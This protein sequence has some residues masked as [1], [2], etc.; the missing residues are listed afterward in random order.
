VVED[1]PAIAEA[2]SED[3]AMGSAETLS[4]GLEDIFFDFDQAVITEVG[5][6]RLKENAAWFSKHRD[7]RVRI[8]GS[9]DERGTSAYNL[10]LGERRALA[11]K[12]YLSALGVEISRV[13]TVSY[14][15]ERPYCMDGTEVCWSQNRRGHFVAPAQASL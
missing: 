2:S 4:I 9:T 6:A 5:A 14:G 13:D 12:R 15:E 11:I 7:S 10:A 3:P 8:E 1:L